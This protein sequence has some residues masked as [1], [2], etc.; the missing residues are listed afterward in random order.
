MPMPVSHEPPVH[1]RT[2]PLVMNGPFM[3]IHM[4]YDEFGESPVLQHRGRSAE[5]PRKTRGRV[6]R[7][8]DFSRVSSVS[9]K[10]QPSYIY[11]YIY[12]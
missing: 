11:I 2:N 8:K 9:I 5:D 6:P 1:E 7:K 4:N 12:I 3:K 10:F